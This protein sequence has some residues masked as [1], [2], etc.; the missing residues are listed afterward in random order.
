MNIV[1]VLRSGQQK[2]VS[3]QQTVTLAD[4]DRNVIAEAVEINSLCSDKSH[5]CAFLF[6]SDSDISHRV[7]LSACI[8]GA[9]EGILIPCSPDIFGNTPLFS[10]VIAR[11]LSFY[12]SADLIL[13]GRIAADGDA[14]YLASMVAEHLSFPRVVSCSHLASDGRMLTAEKYLSETHSHLLR[15]PLPA[16][17][18]SIR[19]KGL[20]R[21]PSVKN[22]VRT[23]AETPVHVFPEKQIPFQE[24]DCV[25]A[26]VRTSFQAS[27]KYMRDKYISL[28]GANDLESARNLLNL[29]HKKGFNVNC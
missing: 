23:Y 14:V 29:L 27:E 26:P 1:V 4:S 12:P 19:E 13:F 28:N 7:L 10:K 18:Q 3:L 2:N 25:P 17:V 6:D 15:C 11:T 9:D 21:Q 22:I 20:R 8:H 24:I 16:V 5:I